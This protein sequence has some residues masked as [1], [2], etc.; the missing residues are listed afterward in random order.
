VRHASVFKNGHLIVTIKS[1]KPR[2]MVED[3]KRTYFILLVPAVIGF[4]VLFF[5]LKL[6]WIHLKLYPVPKMLALTLFILS[7][8]FAVA[9]PIFYRTLFANK[10][11]HQTETSEAEWLKFEQNSIRIALVTPY[12]TLTAHFLDLPK[13]YL[14]G[15]ILMAL[16]AIYYFYPSKKRIAFERR[17][18]RVK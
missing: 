13:F 10:I 8:V 14:S 18:F 16:Y 15:T 17:I 7:V 1:E 6:N 12:L 4:I 5:S 11:R 3:L 9:L 2:Y